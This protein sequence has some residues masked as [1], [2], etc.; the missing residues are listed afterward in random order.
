MLDTL[1]RHRPR[2]SR[3]SGKKMV[4]KKRRHFER[5]ALR[6]KWKGTR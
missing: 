1:I 5:K 2:N 3:H 6:D 4:A